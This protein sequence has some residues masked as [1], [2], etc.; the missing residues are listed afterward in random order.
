MYVNGYNRRQYVSLWK[1][2]YLQSELHDKLLAWLALQI[3]VLSWYQQCQTAHADS[4]VWQYLNL[5][6]LMETLEL[7]SIWHRTKSRIPAIIS[8]AYLPPVAHVFS[9]PTL[10]RST[11]NSS[12]GAAREPLQGGWGPSLSFSMLLT[13][14]GVCFSQCLSKMLSLIFIHHS[15]A[16]QGHF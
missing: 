11:S 15:L 10:G 2:L 5:S 3:A 7:T 8:A 4:N 9:G 13:E 14:E 16:V 6:L 1:V 12:R